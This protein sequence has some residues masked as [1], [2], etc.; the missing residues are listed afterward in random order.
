MIA[1]AQQEPD[2]EPEPDPDP[3]PDP[4][5]E[6]VPTG[7]KLLWEDTFEGPA[8]TRPNTWEYETGPNW[9]N[10][11][12]ACYMRAE[13]VELDGQGHLVL[14]SK[15]ESYGGK[16]YTSYRIQGKRSITKGYLACSAKIETTNGSWPGWWTWGLMPWPN[17]GEIDIYEVLENSGR[18]AHHI[19]IPGANDGKTLSVIPDMATTFHE[20]GAHF[21]ENAVTFYVD[22]QETFRV[23]RKGTW[24]FGTNPQYPVL[25]GNVGD[26]GG[27]PSKGTWPVR[28]TVDWVRAWNRRP[29]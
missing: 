3:T 24:P 23:N 1:A 29:W 2:P 11:K 4:D 27:D 14:A 6:P 5:P 13:N 25:F 22:R 21:D 20:Y 7:A 12:L 18:I 9:E 17:T 16:P 26:Y 8:G 15:K 28:Q 19:H 10:G